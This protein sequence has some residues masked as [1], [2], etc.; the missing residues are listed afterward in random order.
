MATID[1]HEA[2]ALLAGARVARLG[3]HGPDGRLD[4][5]PCTFAPLAD[6]RLVTAVD[7]KPK[8]TTRLQR[9]TNVARRPQVAL[10][11]DRWDDEDWSALWWV[12]VH[13]RASVAEPGTDDHALAVAAL[14]QRYRQYWQR[15]PTG[16]AIVIDPERWLGWRASP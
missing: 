12:R 11:V 10:L 5:V 15:P 8:A 6:G 7:H 16:A 4:L 3:T 14:V 9:L 13:G 2:R 1:Q